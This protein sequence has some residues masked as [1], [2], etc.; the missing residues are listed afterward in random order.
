MLPR[1]QLYADKFMFAKDSVIPINALDLISELKVQEQLARDL[2][3]V[4]AQL[5]Y[6]R[7]K[8]Q[9]LELEMACYGRHYDIRA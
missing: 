5:D 9:R 4:Q 7:D 2:Q 1:E 3:K 8:A 6:W